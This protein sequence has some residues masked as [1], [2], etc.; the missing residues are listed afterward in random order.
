MKSIPYK[1]VIASL[2]FYN[3]SQAL[4]VT[5]MKSKLEIDGSNMKLMNKGSI[6]LEF[7]NAFDNPAF[8]GRSK[9][10]IESKIEAYIH[11]KEIFEILTRNS[12]EMEYKNYFQDLIRLEIKQN[13]LE[14]KILKNNEERIVRL[15]DH[16]KTTVKRF[17]EFSIKYIQGWQCMGDYRLSN[18][19]LGNKPMTH[20]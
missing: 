19:A 17:L 14:W 18:Q 11:E 10:S 9:L 13:A 20:N 2:N 1:N 5:L 8:P 4:S 6:K 15:T 3:K 7:L 12:T 16:E